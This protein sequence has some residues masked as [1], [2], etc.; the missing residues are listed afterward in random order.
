VAKERNSKRREIP[1]AVCQ[2]VPLELA[3][4]LGPVIRAGREMR[5]AVRGENLLF[6]I[7]LAI[8]QPAAPA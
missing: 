6:A 5:F 4:A 8:F 1:H 3:Q 2:R 7:L